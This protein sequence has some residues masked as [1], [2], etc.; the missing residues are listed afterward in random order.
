MLDFPT[1]IPQVVENARV[2]RFRVIDHKF[3]HVWRSVMPR[4]V[5]FLAVLFVG[6]GS[7]VHG[8]EPSKDD[9]MKAWASFRWEM[10]SN[11]ARW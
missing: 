11:N 1:T 7:T 8:E 2:Y 6:L 4:P 5:T 10:E 3:S 9:A